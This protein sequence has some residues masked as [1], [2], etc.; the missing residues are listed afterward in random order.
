MNRDE[1]SDAHGAA[2]VDVLR[3]NV[4]FRRPVIAGVLSTCSITFFV[5]NFRKNEM[6]TCCCYKK[7]DGSD[8]GCAT[9][10]GDS[11]PAIAG[12]TLVSSTPGAC[13]S[14]SLQA[15][16]TEAEKS[17]VANRG[18]QSQKMEFTLASGKKVTVAVTEAAN[19]E[20]GV[21]HV[22]DSVSVADAAQRKLS[23]T[24]TCTCSGGASTSKECPTTSA[25][26]DC[27]DPKNP[28]ITCN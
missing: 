25:L 4:S 7:N 9:V 14:N 15:L 13:A 1:Q 6:A 20:I 2:V 8:A 10:A 11:C 17:L 21:A 24:V 26:C 19:G 5:S 12:Y 18:L 28:K 22:V 16:V 27:S 3:W 23:H